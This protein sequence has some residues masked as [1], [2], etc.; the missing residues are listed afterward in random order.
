[1]NYHD[2]YLKYKKKYTNL[3]KNR[4]DDDKDLEHLMKIIEN[5]QKKE[6]MCYITSE[7]M[8]NTFKHNFV[9]Q[10][11][12]NTANDFQDFMLTNNYTLYNIEIT[13]SSIKIY[14]EGEKQLLANKYNI[15]RKVYGKF[16][17]NKDNLRIFMHAFNIFK[18]N[19]VIIVSQSWYGLHTYKIIHIFTNMIHFNEFI[20]QV[21]HAI[22]IFNK[23][24]YK[25]YALF[26]VSKIDD[27][28]E[29]N[30]LKMVVNE[31]L[32]YNANINIYYDSVD[33][34]STKN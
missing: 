2:K 30:I 21:T 11:T 8:F 3:K 31:N 12:V 27:P 15:N 19:N 13:L 10:K 1:M 23:N 29:D 9:G 33:L 17:F 6:T 16:V 28:N 24:P 4:E 22:S 7:Q 32:Q 18:L 20:K 14:N 25:L 34:L 5:F 26:G